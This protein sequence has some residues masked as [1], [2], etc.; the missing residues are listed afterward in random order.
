MVRDMDGHGRAL[1]YSQQ[2]LQDSDLE[3]F[4]PNAIM[5]TVQARLKVVHSGWNPFPDCSHIIAL[6]SAIICGQRLYLNSTIS[7]TNHTVDNI[8]K[9][10]LFQYDPDQCKLTVAYIWILLMCEHVPLVELQDLINPDY[11]KLKEKIKRGRSAALFSEAFE[12]FWCNYRAV[13]TRRY[14]DGVTVR[15]SDFHSAAAFTGKCDFTFVNQHLS[16]ARAMRQFGTK[17]ADTDVIKLN[18]GTCTRSTSSLIDKVVL[19]CAGAPSGD[20]MVV[21]KRSRRLFCVEGH[22]CK[23]LDF[24]TLNAAAVQ[25]EYQKAVGPGDCFIV[26]SSDKVDRDC[27]KT[28]SGPVAI[29]D[30]DHF[31]NYFGPFAG[32]AFF[33]KH[34]G[35][36]NV[37]L[38]SV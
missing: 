10:G 29:I 22:Q 31:V 12:E 3:F 38:A 34:R 20:S 24:S 16:F 30:E 5:G 37:N 27:L 25:K 8:L 28:L 33:Y 26:I 14:A 36:I 9:V 23:R 4:K 17:Y 18:D 19:N 2:T 6:L 7:G 32:P 11:D 35:P 1:E 15:W 21:L 13:R